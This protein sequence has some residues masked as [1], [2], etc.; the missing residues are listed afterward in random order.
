M[1]AERLPEGLLPGSAAMRD[2]V[3]R[4]LRAYDGV[5]V[6][7]VRTTRIYCRPSCPSRQPKPESIEFY[8]VPEA[9]E[10]AGYRACKRCRP[11]D[12]SAPSADVELVRRAC[13]AIASADTP[14]ALDV[15]ASSL[16][17]G[18][19]RVRRVFARTLGVTPQQYGEA[20][21]T[22]RLR[23]A[24][25]SG[26]PATA[27]VYEAGYGSSSRVYEHAA[28]RLGMTPA[29]YARKGAGMRV[30]WA[31]AP[32]ALGRVLVAAT[33]RGICSVKLG[34]DDRTLARLLEDEFRAAERVH[35]DR[36]MRA[37]V[38]EI[39]ARI[40]GAA[41]RRELPLDVRA[42]AFQWRVWQELQKIPHGE[43]RSYADIARAIGEPRA[44]RA[45]AR[46]CATNPAA[47][48]IPCHRVVHEDGTLSGY[49][50]GVERKEALLRSEAERSARRARRNGARDGAAGE[51]SL[52][53][54]DK[55]GA[56][57]RAAT[58][59]NGRASAKGRKR[60]VR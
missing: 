15:L 20:V 50:W 6:T 26:R 57:V 24:L 43:T 37:L 21:R 2:A 9:A 42:T 54:P 11:N 47:I 31:T 30:T 60:R 19:G 56:K 45:V 44:A 40:E 35:D 36:R 29:T 34:D 23:D 16:G 25:A 8:A 46:A 14:P 17:V 55:R 28:A 32:C 27:A 5:F 49:G 22:R 10:L 1:V 3:A 51:R 58:E 52:G 48:A 33:E 39:V 18:A 41:P 7:A 13:R 53:A 4:R 38:S 12:A 59:A